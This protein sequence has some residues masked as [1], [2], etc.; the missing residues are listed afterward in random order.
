MFSSLR[1]VSTRTD[2][3]KDGFLKR[4]TSD[5]S[6]FSSITIKTFAY[7]FETAKDLVLSPAIMRMDHLTSAHL[8]PVHDEPELAQIRVHIS[9]LIVLFTSLPARRCLFNALS[10]MS[11]NEGRQALLH[12]HVRGRLGLINEPVYGCSISWII[13]SCFGDCQ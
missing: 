8:E 5:N 12:P 13:Q 7:L 11:W 2:M 9:K 10:M 1:S 4:F 6:L 3:K